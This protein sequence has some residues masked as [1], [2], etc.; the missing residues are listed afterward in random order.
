MT[1]ESY[2][3]TPEAVEQAKTIVLSVGAKGSI[4]AAEL[5]AC[6][7]IRV[8]IRVDPVEAYVIALRDEWNGPVP[9]RATNILRKAILAGIELGKQEVGR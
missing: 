4:S 1:Q 7:D 9:V 3:W 2:N 6:R 8:S 5:G